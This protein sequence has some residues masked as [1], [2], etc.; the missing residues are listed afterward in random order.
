MFYQID[1]F[2]IAQSKQLN[3]GVI[4]QKW[5]VYVQIDEKGNFNQ[6][7]ELLRKVLNQGWDGITGTF[8]PGNDLYSGE[9]QND[10]SAGNLS[11]PHQKCL[12][13]GRDGQFDVRIAKLTWQLMMDV[14]FLSIISTQQICYICW[15]PVSYKL[16]PKFL[17]IL[18]ENKDKL[19]LF[20]IIIIN[21]KLLQSTQN[22]RVFSSSLCHKGKLLHS[23]LFF[24]HY[25]QLYSYII[26]WQINQFK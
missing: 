6:I 11:T 16:K 23:N 13:K 12:H 19:A 15:F 20:R 8:S 17:Q 5:H 3:R 9:Y 22:F 18:G 10:N 7:S 24:Y 1:Q 14:V 2:I 4:L 21:L 26:P 25:N